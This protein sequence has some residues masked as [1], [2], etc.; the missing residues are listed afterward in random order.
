MVTQSLEVIEVPLCRLLDA[1]FTLD[2][3]LL[4]VSGKHLTYSASFP[5]VRFD[6]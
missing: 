2:A 5:C 6:P 4:R 1:F 3:K